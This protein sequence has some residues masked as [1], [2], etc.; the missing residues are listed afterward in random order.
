[1]TD[2]EYKM[3][4]KRSLLSDRGALLFEWLREKGEE[5][6]LG[7]EYPVSVSDYYNDDDD[8]EIAV[9]AET[10]IPAPLSSSLR[11]QSY[12]T[13]LK[14]ILGACPAELV[15]NRG[16]LSLIPNKGKDGLLGQMGVQKSDMFNI[17][18]WIWEVKYVVGIPL[19]L[20]FTVLA[21]LNKAEIPELNERLTWKLN[22]QSIRL[23][24]MR[25]C[26]HDGMGRGVWKSVKPEYVMCPLVPDVLTCIKTF[27]PLGKV[28]ETNAD[29]LI[30]FMGYET[31]SDFLYAALACRK[32]DLTT[33]SKRL[34]RT[35][36]GEIGAES[37]NARYK[38][39]TCFLPN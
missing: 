14:N 22:S 33:M 17:L 34:G 4:Q 29:E 5:F 31:P 10:I 2:K 13:E 30:E 35:L 6:K 28:D 37:W 15:K 11:R 32:Y 18:D 24:L 23:S 39:G 26:L 9:V 25:L 36:S 27:C 12:V 8:I 16:F 7:R 3:L 20:A 1:M 19:E 21:G 38:R